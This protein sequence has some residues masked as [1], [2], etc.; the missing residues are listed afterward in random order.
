MGFY[1]AKIH[2][3]SLTKFLMG[4]FDH[5]N[6]SLVC[7]YWLYLSVRSKETCIH[8]ILYTGMSFYITRFIKTSHSN[9]FSL[10][11]FVLF[12]PLYIFKTIHLVVYVVKKSRI[13][14]IISYS[15]IL[16]IP[17]IHLHNSAVFHESTYVCMVA[18]TLC[19]NIK[20][21]LFPLTRQTLTFCTYLKLL[22]L[23]PERL[24]TCMSTNYYP[25][26]WPLNPLS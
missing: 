15:S 8:E 10:F 17:V 24:F 12:Y 11:Y 7:W 19:W 26:G 9:V 23:F 22:G 16:Q 6:W 13:S 3:S 5:V 2:Q 14:I 1:S 4:H 20:I 18:L 21:S 25:L